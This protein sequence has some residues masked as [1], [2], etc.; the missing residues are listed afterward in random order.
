ME[1]APRVS[2]KRFQGPWGGGV[3]YAQMLMVSVIGVAL[4]TQGIYDSAN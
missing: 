4:E 3:L 2:A 1:A